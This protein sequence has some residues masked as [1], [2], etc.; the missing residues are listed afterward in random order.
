VASLFDELK[1]EPISSSQTKLTRGDHRERTLEEVLSLSAARESPA[2]QHR[3]MHVEA[4]DK[5]RR[6]IQRGA[7]DTLCSVFR[8][9]IYIGPTGLTH[10][11]ISSDD[12][13]YCCS[14]FQVTRLFFYQLFVAGFGNFGKIE[15]AQP[16]DINWLADLMPHGD[17]NVALELER[18]REM[19][20]DFF[21]MSVAN[22]R[23]LAMPNV[24]PGY[25]PSFTALPLF[26]VRLA[27]EV[28][29][30]YEFD[31]IAA[32]ISELSM[33][34]AILP[35]D[36]QDDEQKVRITGELKNVIFPAMKTAAFLPTLWLLNDG[37][38]ARVASIAE[39]YSV[40]ER[41]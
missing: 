37:S 39:M 34:Y 2:G 9:H 7:N 18:N 10:A 25:Q 24:L 29:W 20:A 27:T 36:A 6:Q 30:D 13:L 38:V 33:L 17:V 23:L 8:R 4:I 32:V 26:L 5:L 28:D 1:Y 41:T 15:F 40:F 11:F 19:L 22:G 31:C 12:T 16:I 14:L 3:D 21:A 35:E